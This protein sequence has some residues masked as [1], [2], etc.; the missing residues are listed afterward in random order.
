MNVYL[1]KR[2]ALYL[3]LLLYFSGLLAGAAWAD[4]GVLLPRDKQQPDP[5]VLSLDE[6]AVSIVIDNGEAH[7]SVRQ[8]FAN[9]TRNI[10][11]GQYVFA[12]S[13]HAT[14]SDFAVWDGPVRIPAVILERKRAQQ[15][16]DALKP[17]AVDPGLLQMG[18]KGADEARRT[19]VFSAKIVPIPAY[20]TKRLELE[21][22]ETIP[23]ENL[24]SYFAFPLRPDAYHMQAAGRLTID[25]ELRSAHP[26][27]RFQVGGKVW[28]LHFT[29]QNPN[30][31]K[32]SLD[33]RNVN[34]S[35]DF[36]V[37]YDLD[38]E[39]S[40]SARVITHR[41]P[42][43]DQP[44]PTVRRPEISHNEPGFFEV[45]ALLGDS[46]TS[47]ATAGTVPS[48]AEVAG[49][50]RNL[51]I[52]FD[53]SLSMQWEKLDRSYQAMVAALHTLGSK[54]SFNLLLFNSQVNPY[55]PAMV[56]AS[57]DALGKAV[58]FVRASR[59]RGGTDLDK[60]LQMALA[61]C[62]QA[63]SGN[64]YILLLSDGGATRGMIRGSKIAAAYAQ[65]WKALPEAQRPRTFV[66][67]VG[68]DA[69]L[70]LLKMLASN[71]G[72]LENVLSTEPIDFK[73]ESFLSKIGCRPIGNLGLSV[74]PQD[75]V[76]MV[77][78]LQTASFSNRSEE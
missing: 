6:M 50:S 33:L 5:S 70:P 32:G 3:L 75:S 41:Q 61:Q 43:S 74:S 7:V 45:E 2:I 39:A 62:A 78:P 14:I 54:D 77:Y 47:S 34:L 63:K 18:E 16:Y 53:T 51:V 27:R 19:S 72:V 30:L 26:I 65:Q 35:E 68:D 21:Y 73:L 52:L 17:Q 40:D 37:Q 9:H 24:R 42:D 20:A 67:A 60:A 13:S 44:D 10:E 29:T 64:N 12:L 59:L 11:E 15:I 55:Q 71:E 23:V 57:E 69:N 48:T 1:A 38:P 8:I 76:S 4:A 56:A 31:I 46:K 22:H 58:Q 28:P 36:S 66:F 25:F 49:A